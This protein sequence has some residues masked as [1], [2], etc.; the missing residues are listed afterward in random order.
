MTSV[1]YPDKGRLSKTPKWNLRNPGGREVFGPGASLFKLWSSG[2]HAA[3]A[4]LEA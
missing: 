4:S 1:L 3:L 2:Q